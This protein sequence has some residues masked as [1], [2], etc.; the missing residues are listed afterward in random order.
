MWSISV[1][2]LGQATH[3]APLPPHTKIVYDH[4]KNTLLIT[5][6][7][8]LSKMYLSTHCHILGFCHIHVHVLF[9]VFVIYYFPCHHFL[10]CILVVSPMHF[11]HSVSTSLHSCFP[12]DV[13]VPMF[14]P[15]LFLY[16]HSH[17]HV[18]FIYDSRY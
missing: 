6:K 8:Y 9:Y 14:C 5:F 1:N 18:L 10:F 11:I 2:T 7:M 12:R 17:F 13:C 3:A 16:T 4:I 15:R